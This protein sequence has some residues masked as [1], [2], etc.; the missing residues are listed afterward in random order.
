MAEE[1]PATNDAW[2]P[3][4]APPLFVRSQSVLATLGLVEN[5]LLGLSTDLEV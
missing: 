4:L 3:A 2:R 5:R 1:R